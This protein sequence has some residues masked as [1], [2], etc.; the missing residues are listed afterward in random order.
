DGLPIGSACA[1]ASRNRNR[2]VLA[3][4]G[5]YNKPEFGPCAPVAATLRTDW[6]PF[7][8]FDKAVSLV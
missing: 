5:A 4:P 7:G 3:V 1:P 2:E 8:L 6:G